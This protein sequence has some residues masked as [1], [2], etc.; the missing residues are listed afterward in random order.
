LVLSEIRIQ[1]GTKKSNLIFFL[2]WTISPTK[3]GNSV[4]PRKQGAQFLVIG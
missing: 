3:I 4:L 1:L 2:N